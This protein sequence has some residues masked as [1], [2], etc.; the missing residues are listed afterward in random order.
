MN[1]FLAA[2]LVGLFACQGSAQGTNEQ[3]SSARLSERAQVVLA[4]HIY[5][6][7]VPVPE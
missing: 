7:W 4:M 3:L 2:C 1:I 5:D 6:V